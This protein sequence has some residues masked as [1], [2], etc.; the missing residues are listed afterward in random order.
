MPN[1]RRNL[2][3]SLDS[4]PGGRSIVSIKCRPSD[5]VGTWPV[6]VRKRFAHFGNSICWAG[7]RV[8]VVSS[9]LSNIRESFS[10]IRHSLPIVREPFT[11]TR[12]PL[13]SIRESFTNIREPFPSIRESFTRIRESFTGIRESFT[14]IR[15]T[16]LPNRITPLDVRKQTGNQYRFQQLTTNRRPRRRQK[17]KAMA[18][19]IPDSDAEFNTWLQ[20]FTHYA[21][22]RLAELGLVAAD[23]APLTAAQSDWDTAYSDSVA[24]QAAAQG[25]SQTKNTVRATAEAVVRPLVKRIQ[26]QPVVSDAHR[27][28]LAISY[29]VPNARPPGCP[30]L[31][32]SG[33]STPVNG[34]ATRSTS[35]MRARRGGEASPKASRDVRSG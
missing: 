30:S 16:I 24:T 4:T 7:N 25:A 26:S 9:S 32:Q 13:A 31:G 35:A 1:A 2:D 18:D 29:P 10:N 3:H 33:L 15:E 22:G 6:I 23:L 28:G 5:P 19:Y 11:N 14:G 27:A 17:E 20:N 21:S 12:E 8:L 34:C